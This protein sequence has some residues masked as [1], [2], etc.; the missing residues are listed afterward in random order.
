MQMHEHAQSLAALMVS[1]EDA[2]QH[3]M[4]CGVP[5]GDAAVLAG[6]YSLYYLLHLSYSLYLLPLTSFLLSLLLSLRPSL[7]LLTSFLLSLLPSLL[8]SILM[9]LL[10]FL[11]LFLLLM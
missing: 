9:S 1:G 5:S 2:L 3:V 10:S 11:Q 7:L 8:R 4:G 6:Y